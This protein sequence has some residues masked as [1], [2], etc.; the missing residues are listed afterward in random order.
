MKDIRHLALSQLSEEIPKCKLNMSFNQVPLNIPSKVLEL[1]L[2]DT[3]FKDNLNKLFELIENKDNLEDRLKEVNQRINKTKLLHSHIQVELDNNRFIS[4]E[5]YRM[6][7]DELYNKH[8]DIKVYVIDTN[9]AI[10]TDLRMS[11]KKPM[12]HRFL[13]LENDIVIAKEEFRKT[14]LRDKVLNN[15]TFVES[16]VIGVDKLF[17]SIKRELR[18]EELSWLE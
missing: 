6:Y 11:Y 8:P 3:V 2:F 10:E 13:N 9:T 4:T 12:L 7:I 16:D 17:E 14:I 5:L 15:V 1:Y 18:E